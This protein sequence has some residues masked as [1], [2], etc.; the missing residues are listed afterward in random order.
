MTTDYICRACSVELGI[1]RASKHWDALGVCPYCQER[2]VLY[3][4]KTDEHESEK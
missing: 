1:K 2:H 4:V 3:L